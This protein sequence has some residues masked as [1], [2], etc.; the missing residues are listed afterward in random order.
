[1]GGTVDHRGQCRRDRRAARACRRKARLWWLRIRF[2]SAVALQLAAARPD[3]VAAL[4][5]L[6]R[7]SVWTAG[8]LMKIADAMLASPDYPDAAE[9]RAGEGHR[10][11][12]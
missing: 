9:A 12:G 10:L 7:R 8:G 1:M 5:L 3:R 2:G 6:T 11:V 4:V